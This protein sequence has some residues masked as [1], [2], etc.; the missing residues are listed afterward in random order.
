MANQDLML[1]IEELDLYLTWVQVQKILGSQ[2][3]RLEC[4]L[5]TSLA[6]YLSTM[7][8]STLYLSIL[9]FHG[10]GQTRNV[11]NDDS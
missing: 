2:P 10:F 4:N 3:Q 11:E 7:L 6:V 9:F 8:P 5:V 1:R